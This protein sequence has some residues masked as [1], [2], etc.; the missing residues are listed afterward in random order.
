[1]EIELTRRAVADEK[2][3]LGIC[4]GVQVFNVALGGTLVQDIPD[5]LQSDLRHSYSTREFPGNHPAHTVK[6]EEETLLARILGAPIVTV[7]SRH[8]QSVK[9]VAPRLEVAA[10]AP[11]GVIHV[12]MADPEYAQADE[13]HRIGSELGPQAQKG[14]GDLYVRGI[15]GEVR[16]MNLQN[17]K[18]HNDGKDA[19]AQRL[20]SVFSQ[21]DGPGFEVR[22]SH[23]PFFPR[24]VFQG[25]TPG[26]LSGI[27][28]NESRVVI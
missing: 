17:Q 26:T 6:V 15:R 16:N 13:A 24:T 8:H 18:S 19:V 1:V 3:F 10:R 28:Y 22:G 11:D 2:P 4:R 14:R 25:R 5:E 20:D 23:G 7:N 27:R 9:D 12:V 21:L